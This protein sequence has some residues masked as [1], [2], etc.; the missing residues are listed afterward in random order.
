MF[1]LT[2]TQKCNANSQWAFNSLKVA[3]TPTE[4][5]PL[6]LLQHS[7]EDTLFYASSTLPFFLFL[8]TSRAFKRK[9]TSLVPLMLLFTEG[10]P[11]LLPM[12][13]GLLPVLPPRCASCHQL[14]E[15]NKAAP[16]LQEMSYR[17]MC[18][19]LSACSAVEQ[20]M[21]FSRSPGRYC[22]GSTNQAAPS[23]HGH[24]RC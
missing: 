14:A 24:S 15:S 16:S 10:N 1:A 20:W 19:W 22:S 3:R 9:G 12:Y 23:K 7:L 6:F 8:N 5:F 17:K 11:S 13:T 21:S 4:A 18:G 2:N